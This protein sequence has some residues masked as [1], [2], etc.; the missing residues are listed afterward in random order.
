LGTQ[1]VT[2]ALPADILRDAKHLA[3]DQGVSL[4]RF[5]A[6]LIEEKVATSRQYREA[7]ERQTRLMREGLDL[8]TY[9]KITWTR[10]DLY[11]R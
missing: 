6:M 11:E 10:D 3:V 2:L 8:G 4:S 9:G 1:N 5:L 7:R